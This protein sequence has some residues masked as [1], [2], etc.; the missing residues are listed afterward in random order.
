MAVPLL[1]IVTSPFE[2]ASRYEPR[3]SDVGTST[4]PADNA[5]RKEVTA[6]AELLGG[7]SSAD[8]VSEC[9]AARSSRCEEIISPPSLVGSALPT[10]RAVR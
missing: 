6:K 5:P 8:G 9:W 2:S 7:E 3:A 1:G 4:E 10:E